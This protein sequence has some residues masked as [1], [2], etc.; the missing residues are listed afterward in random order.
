LKKGFQVDSW[1]KKDLINLL[2]ESEKNQ[3]PSKKNIKKD[4]AQRPK[5]A[6]WTL[7]SAS[8][9]PW[10]T[11]KKM[12]GGEL[13]N[14][15]KD[16]DVTATN[17]NA[18]KLRTQL[19]DFIDTKGGVM[20][21]SMIPGQPKTR[22]P[23]T[24]KPAPKKAAPKK[25]PNVVVTAEIDE[26]L[27]SMNAGMLRKL[28]K[29]LGIAA[30]TWNQTSLRK[31]IMEARRNKPE[32]PNKKLKEDS[33][34]KPKPPKKEIVKPKPVPAQV[35]TQPK[36]PKK[37]T[38]KPKPVQ[39]KKEPPKLPPSPEPRPCP[40]SVAS[41]VAPP[42]QNL[43][44]AGPPPV[45]DRIASNIST[46]SAEPPFEELKPPDLKIPNN[47]ETREASVSAPPPPPPRT[48]PP[49]KKKSVLLKNVP[50]TGPPTPPK[51][52]KPL[53]ASKQKDLKNMWEKK[54]KAV[55]EEQKYNAFSSSYD[56]EATEK[57]M[58]D[59]NEKGQPK[60]GTRSHARM[61]AAQKWASGKIEQLYNLFPKIPG[62]KTLPDGRL[63]NTFGRIFNH[64]QDVDCVIVG[65][66]KSAK[67]KG[68][69]QY[70]N[71]RS[72]PLLQQSFDD[73]VTVTLMPR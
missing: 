3:A 49:P 67:K 56:K 11:F 53:R 40:A 8:K 22:K 18:A 55:R 12:K 39:V 5:P 68:F 69:I 65:T 16:L 41:S 15:L 66:L 34:D 42:P 1:N 35:K 72:F 20:P 7:Q 36:P 6:K 59:S 61:V 46:A 58:H 30:K 63:E 60:E 4:P 9:E 28:C 70:D 31:Q 32:D 47:G 73:E 25:S 50:K 27:M 13:R 10:S 71:K 48:G 57:R 45:P 54:D 24:T 33:V 29:E 52:N 14:V 37:E 38:V 43:L 26:D 23:K 17:W 21:K 2:L 64:Y 51:V 62:C 19:K 44:P